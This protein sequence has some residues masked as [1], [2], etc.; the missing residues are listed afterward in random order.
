MQYEMLEQ[1]ILAEEHGLS[2][3]AY[4]PSAKSLNP[5]NLV[6]SGPITQLKQEDINSLSSLGWK[7]IPPANEA[8]SKEE[9]LYAMMIENAAMSERIKSL[10]TEGVKVTTQE[11]A[12]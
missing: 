4:I 8:S 3:S 5:V 11:G 2:F 7:I 9:Q 6:R 10:L 12:E 1:Q